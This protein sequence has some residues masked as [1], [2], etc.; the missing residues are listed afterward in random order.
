MIQKFRKKPVVI[1]AV[2]FN[3]LNFD[4]IA[5]FVLPMQL[6]LGERLAGSSTIQIPTL[7]GQMTA[8]KGDWII[9]G[10]K[11]VGMSGATK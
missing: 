1:E 8:Q 2:Y 6:S 7:E 11:K 9:K 10:V 4:E 5:D 3:G